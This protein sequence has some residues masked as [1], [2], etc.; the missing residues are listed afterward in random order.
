MSKHAHLFHKWIKGRIDGIRPH[1]I[2]GIQFSGQLNVWKGQYRYRIVSQGISTV[3]DNETYI[4]VNLLSTN[5][6]LDAGQVVA[7]AAYPGPRDQLAVVE[8]DPL[9]VVAV[10]QVVQA[11]VSDQRTVVQLCTQHP[12]LLARY[13]YT[14]D[15]TNGTRHRYQLQNIIQGLRNPLYC[16]WLY[17][18]YHKRNPPP[19]L[20]TEHQIGLTEPTTG[21]PLLA[22]AGTA[23]GTFTNAI[24]YSRQI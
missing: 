3:K 21:I 6:D 1:Q 2:S 15:T 11:L 20:A 4:S 17:R 16:Y 8:L 19:L 7:E 5:P 12:P 9:Q 23:Y 13:R 24:G 22:T 14:A 10:H 18:R